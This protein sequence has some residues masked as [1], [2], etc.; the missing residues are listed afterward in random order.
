MVVTRGVI[1]AAGRGTRLGA[2][3]E[4]VP[5]PLV[6]VAGVAVV[7]HIVRSMVA[8]GVR[9]LTVVTGYLAAEIEHHLARSC[10]VPVSFVRQPEM[11]GT[12]GA[13]R[14]VERAVGYEPFML[15][16]GDI[17]T[18]RDHYLLVAEAFRAGLAGTIGVNMLED[19]SSGSSVVFGEDLVIS[20]VIEK[21]QAPAPSPWNSAGIMILGPQVWAHLAT[22]RPSQRGEFELP[23]AMRTM[24]ADGELLKAVPLTGDWFDIGTPAT[25]DAARAG[26]GGAESRNDGGRP[27]APPIEHHR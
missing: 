18:S 6:E 8:A 9:L 25:L 20:D 17:V 19:V 2:L 4:S 5:K 14:L 13:L 10:P 24:V 12:A 27:Q 26:L 23:D 22:L 3:T 11:N 15:S 1:L 21:P 7:D 16:W